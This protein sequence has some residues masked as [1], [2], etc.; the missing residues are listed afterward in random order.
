MS[1]LATPVEIANIALT[2][3]LGKQTIS[4]FSQSGVEATRCRVAYPIALEQ[5]AQASDWSFLRERAALAL[6]ANDK[7]QDYVYAYDAPSR[8]L[9]LFYLVEPGAPKTP[10]RHYLL[11]GGK[12]Y[13]NLGEAVAHYVTLQGKNP[14]DWPVHFKMAIAAKM[15][16]LMA[17]SFTR[18]MSNKDAY[19][20][21]AVQELGLAIE[22][23]AAQE[24]TTYTE[25]YSYVDGRTDARRTGPAHDGSTF[26]GH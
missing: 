17:V 19:R 26:W 3:Y 14:A 24:F 10:Y 12:I 8:A 16:E 21:L 18:N 9:K 2:V 5:T 15:A 11:E 22:Q 23:D 20:Q 1:T 6:V 25:D 13:T 4:S 7:E